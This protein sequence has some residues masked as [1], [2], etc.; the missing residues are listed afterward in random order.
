MN[1]RYCSDFQTRGR[2]QIGNSWESERGKNLT[3]S[4]V[5][6]PTNVIARD[7]FIILIIT[8]V[9]ICDALSKY[10][11]DISVNGLMISIGKIKR[12]VECL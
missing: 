4:T 10:T 7:Q 11:D 2:G 12:Y 8:S 1:I 6:Y 3:F 5:V 9:A